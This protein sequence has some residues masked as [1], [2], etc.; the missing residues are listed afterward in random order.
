[1]ELNNSVDMLGNLVK[2]NLQNW[3]IFFLGINWCCTFGSLVF[4]G[5]TIWTKYNQSEKKMLLSLEV[6]WYLTDFVNLHE[7]YSQNPYSYMGNRLEDKWKLFHKLTYL[8]SRS[9]LK[10]DSSILTRL[11]SIA[12]DYDA[13]AHRLKHWRKMMMKTNYQKCIRNS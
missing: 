13:F 4:I 11:K 7:S 8:V 10:I 3:A 9:E 5:K 6:S 12:N 2:E 1:M